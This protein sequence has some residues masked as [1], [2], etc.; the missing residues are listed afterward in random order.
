MC[1]FVGIESG[2]ETDRASLILAGCKS[3]TSKYTAQISLIWDVDKTE[4]IAGSL[5]IL[6]LLFLLLYSLGLNKEAAETW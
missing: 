2:I 5:A 6:S 4:R 1:V 3:H